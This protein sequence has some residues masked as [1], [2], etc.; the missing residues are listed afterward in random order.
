MRSLTLLLVLSLALLRPASAQTG[1]DCNHL[2]AWL[3]YIE[4]TGFPTHGQLADS[5]VALGVKRV[6]V[7]VADGSP[8]PAVWP[9][10]TDPSVPNAYKQR[11]LEVWAWS[12]NYPTN[13]AQQANALLTAAQTGYEGYIVDVEAEFDGLTTPL[14][15]LFSAFKTKKTQAINT[16]AADSTFQLYCTTWGN[17]MDHNFKINLIDPHVD[18]FMPQTYVEQWGPSFVQNLTQ[19]IA[20]GDQE[21]ATLGATKPVHHIV[22][23]EDGNIS[24]AQ[25]NEFIIA[26]GPETSLWRI[27]GGGVS[28]TLWQTWRQINW[29]QDFCTIG[30]DN[31]AELARL[32]VFPNPSYDFLTLRCPDRAAARIEL[33]DALGRVVLTQN[34]AAGTESHVIHWPAGT[35]SGMYQLVW[36]S[37]EGA[38]SAR[39]VKL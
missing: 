29:N 39:V 38:A 4:I 11:G 34:I 3:W 12:Y 30:T 23:L 13:P 28:P 20:V 37:A 9:E 32:E 10:L 19:W 16:G 14:T 26:S 35:T 24:A 5:L 22:A 15:N 2:G 8:N 1:V 21:Y 18:G 31:P 6:F 33:T 36:H 25:I 7:K 27:P 17:P